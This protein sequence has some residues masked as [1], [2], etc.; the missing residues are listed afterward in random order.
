MIF[1]LNELVHWLG[2]TIFEIWI[3]LISLTIFTILLALKLDNEYFMDNSGWWIVFSPLFVADGLNTYFCAIIFIRMHMGSMIK[4]GILRALWSLISL[5]LVF[6][7]KY[8][9][10]KKLSAQSTLEYSEVLSPVFILLQLIA[11]RAC[12]LH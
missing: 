2:L 5:L 7:F 11:I 6:V 3:N 9:L 12:Q 8:L 10:C 1:S 4:V